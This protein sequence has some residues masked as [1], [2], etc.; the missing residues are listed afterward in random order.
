MKENDEKAIRKLIE[1]C[2]MM[3]DTVEYFGNDEEEFKSN[4]FYQNACSFIIMQIGEYS[5]RLSDEF[6]RTH[7][8]IPWGEIIGMRVLHAHHYEKV[9]DEIVWESIQVDIPYLKYSLE[10]LL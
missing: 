2:D 8:D 10:K 7:S 3:H 6:Q 4:I 5:N 9:I 1:Y